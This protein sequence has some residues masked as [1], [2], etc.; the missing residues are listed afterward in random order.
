[1]PNGDV[2]RDMVLDVNI[3]RTWCYKTLKKYLEERACGRVMDLIEELHDNYQVVQN[4][5]YKK[6]R[7]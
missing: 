7:V 2:A 6:A 5:L 3:K 4:G 1:V